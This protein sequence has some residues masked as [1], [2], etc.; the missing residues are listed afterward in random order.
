MYA[1]AVQADWDP[2]EVSCVH[3]IHVLQRSQWRLMQASCWQQPTLRQGLL[4]EV[5][6][7]RVPARRLRFHA[8]VV[9][10]TRSRYARKWYAHLHAPCLKDSFLD[11]VVLRI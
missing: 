9:K 2:D 4:Q 1:A 8:R 11:L 5:R 7:E 3:T 10:R 6:Q